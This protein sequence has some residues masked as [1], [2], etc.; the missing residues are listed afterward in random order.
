MSAYSPSLALG[1]NNFY[2]I[3]YLYRVHGCVLVVKLNE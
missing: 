2:P 3:C 1:L